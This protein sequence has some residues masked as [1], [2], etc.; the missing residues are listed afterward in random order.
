VAGAGVTSPHLTDP[1]HTGGPQAPGVDVC[2]VPEKLQHI[3]GLR[4]QGKPSPHLLHCCLLR[5]LGYLSWKALHCHSLWALCSTCC[6]AYSQFL[7]QEL[8]HLRE[9]YQQQCSITSSLEGQNRL[10][11]QQLTD[12]KQEW[13]SDKQQMEQQLQQLQG[14][15]CATNGSRCNPGAEAARAGAQRHPAAAAEMR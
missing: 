1:T 11:K 9:L 14:R 7:K 4:A 15:R 2:G 10:L 13:R 8:D 5:C 6:V 12:A 3:N